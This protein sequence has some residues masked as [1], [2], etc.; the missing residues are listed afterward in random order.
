MYLP[1]SNHCHPQK[2]LT[3]E[4]RYWVIW[5]LLSAKGDV[6]GH[7]NY[8]ILLPTRH[9]ERIKTFQKRSQDLLQMAC[10]RYH[11]NRPLE[12]YSSIKD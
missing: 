6:W 3:S 7:K 5:K 10:S 9:A 8:Q 11:R 12:A 1:A 4:S 2:H